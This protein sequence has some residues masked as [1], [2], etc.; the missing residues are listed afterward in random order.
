MAHVEFSEAEVNAI[1]EQF[2]KTE[3]KTQRQI[4]CRAILAAEQAK[5]L[6]RVLI[7]QIDGNQF[8]DSRLIEDAKKFLSN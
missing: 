8:I 2:D 5:T 7:D 1:L 3:A 6:V 4:I